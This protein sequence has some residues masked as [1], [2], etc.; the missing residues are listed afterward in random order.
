MYIDSQPC[1]GTPCRTHK[2]ELFVVVVVG[3]VYVKILSP[4]VVFGRQRSVAPRC[5]LLSPITM[6]VGG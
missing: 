2:P 5:S 6:G 3:N 4:N 1:R